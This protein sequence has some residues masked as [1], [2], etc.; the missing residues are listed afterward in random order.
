M[1]GKRFCPAKRNMQEKNTNTRAKCTVPHC[2]WPRCPR[3]DV[4]GAQLVHGLC[5]Y[6]CGLAC[7]RICSV[8]MESVWLYPGPELWNRMAQLSV[9]YRKV[10]AW[11]HRALRLTF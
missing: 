9:H 2:F 11:T 8:G 10:V 5:V 7:V 4:K 1:D 3:R 6:C